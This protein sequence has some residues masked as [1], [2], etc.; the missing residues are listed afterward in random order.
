MPLPYIHAIKGHYVALIAATSLGLVGCSD[1][2]SAPSPSPSPSSYTITAIDGYLYKADVYAGDD[3]L[4]KSN[5]LGV[6]DQNGELQ[7]DSKYQDK[8]IC[9]VAVDGQTI[10]MGRGALV[11]ASFELKAPAGYDIVSPMTNLVAEQVDAGVAEEQAKQNVV[12]AV[13]PD[14]SPIDEDLLFGDY[15]ADDS[16]QAQAIE[17]I[18][19]TLVDAE[20]ADGNQAMS[21]DNKLVATEQLSDDIVDEISSNNGDLPESYA[22]VIVVDDSGT[23]TLT[24]N[25]KP[26]QVA[27]FDAPITQEY[28]L[29][30]TVRSCLLILM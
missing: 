14:E 23:P 19:E 1:D 2:D 29:G 28:T 26:E 16:T 24:E 7:I 3:C 15:V 10:D 20:T 13:S 11:Q 27:G 6:T 21:I 8:Q 5:K 9:V 30:L 18:A 4:T 22:P 12:A 17:L 25:H